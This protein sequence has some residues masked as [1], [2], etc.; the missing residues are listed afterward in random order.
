L[1]ILAIF[2]S[3]KLD[4]LFWLGWGK[5]TLLKSGNYKRAFAKKVCKKIIRK[6][7]RGRILNTSFSL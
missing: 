4:V 2:K 7:I 3:V 1:S 5:I 6:K